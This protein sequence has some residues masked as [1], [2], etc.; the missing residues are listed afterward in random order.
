[1]NDD[2]SPAIEILRLR[3]ASKEEELNKLKRVVN[4]LCAD[5]NKAPLYPNV[6][7]DSAAT[8]QLRSDLFYGQTITGAARQY[9]EMRKSSGQG[10]APVEAIYQ[11]LKSGGYAFETKNEE[12]AKTGVRITLRKNSATFHRL[13]NGEYGLCAWYG[14][15]GK[16]EEHIPAKKSS[17]KKRKL[18]AAAKAHSAN[19]AASGTKEVM[20]QAVGI[21]GSNGVITV[22]ELESFVREKNRR[23]AGVTAHFHVTEDVVQK[24]LE[25][26]S[27]VYL[28]DRGWLRVRE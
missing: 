15:K 27:K 13:P 2:L 12:N 26:A 4:G 10:A 9:L 7:S 22:G 1:V 18:K 14:V 25:P 6:G 20:R 17:A 28:A 23:I 5:D 19:E 3:V 16:D 24:L 21:A 11:A 8:A